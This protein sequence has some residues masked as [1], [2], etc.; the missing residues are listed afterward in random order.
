MNNPFDVKNYKGEIDWT[1]GNHAHKISI[2]QS[3]VVNRRRANNEEPSQPYSSKGRDTEP[4]KFALAMPVMAKYDK[5][6]ARRK[7]RQEKRDAKLQA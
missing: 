4:G 1:K 5:N 6:A 3:A 7:K 2:Q